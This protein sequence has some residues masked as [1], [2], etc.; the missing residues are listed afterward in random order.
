MISSDQL[1]EG[2]ADGSATQISLLARHI[3]VK[4]DSD[5]A[6][7]VCSSV[8]RLQPVVNCVKFRSA[9]VTAAV[10]LADVKAFF[11]LGMGSPR[12]K[13]LSSLIIN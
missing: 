7:C 2:P 13:L 4:L 9:L 5:L 3:L 6:M 10:A 11:Q 1:N 8:T 12:N